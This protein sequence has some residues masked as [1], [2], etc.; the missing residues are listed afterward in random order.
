MDALPEEEEST[1]SY[2]HMADGGGARGMLPVGWDQ[3]RI[4]TMMEGRHRGKSSAH[5]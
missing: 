2:T 1:L 3:P 4:L 5:L